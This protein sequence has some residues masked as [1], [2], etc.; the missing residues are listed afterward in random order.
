M[1]V[2][3]NLPMAF[4]ALFLLLYLNTRVFSEYVYSSTVAYTLALA[5]TGLPT[6]V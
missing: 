2:V 4:L 3:Y 1:L 5:T 6:E